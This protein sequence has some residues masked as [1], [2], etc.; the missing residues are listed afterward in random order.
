MAERNIDSEIIRLYF[1]NGES[2]I[3]TVRAYK[4]DNKC[5]R[6]PFD[7]CKVRRVI[8]K[9]NQ[10]KFKI[11]RDSGSGRPS[12]DESIRKE[13][14][15]VA[16]N[17]MFENPRGVTSV[18]A[19]A[20]RCEVSKSTVH[21]ILHEDF[22][23]P[24]KPRKVQALLPTDY[25]QRTSFASRALQDVKIDSVLWSDEAYFTLEG[26]VTSVRG[27]VW[28][29]SNPH[30]KFEKPLQSK[31]V[32]VWCGFTSDL[33]IEPFFMDDTLNGDR[34]LSMLKTHVLPILRRKRKLS[35]IIFQQDG[36]PPHIKNNVKQFL[37]DTFS[38]RVISRH[39]EFTWPPR[40]PDL[41]PLDF[42]FWGFVK[43]KVYT[44]GIFASID[45]LIAKI[46]AVIN[47]IPLSNFAKAV[48]SVP[49]RLEAVIQNDGG[50][51]EHF[52]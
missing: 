27:S 36:A 11:E 15:N 47:D 51:I 23:K 44:E 9:F 32:L 49:S 34:Y 33:V 40:S 14:V 8:Q 46:R 4:R 41:S 16:N 30:A 13:V 31:K 2:P 19:V 38:H 25:E 24:Y 42:W 18:R 1:V 6:A 17:L 45:E 39:F 28:A 7:E 22:Y 29:T 12:Y 52:R 37:N 21:R 43:S 48:A 3:E 50:H 35:S 10:G 20:Q 26:D 5:R